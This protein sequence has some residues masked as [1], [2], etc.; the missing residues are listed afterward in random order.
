MALGYNDIGS[1][2]AGDIDIGSYQSPASGIVSCE[3]QCYLDV[4]FSLDSG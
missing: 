4:A 1:W 2:Q 3:M